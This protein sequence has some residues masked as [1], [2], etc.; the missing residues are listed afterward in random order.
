MIFKLGD[1]CVYCAVLVMLG[2]SAQAEPAKK[3]RSHKNLRYG[4]TKKSEKLHADRGKTTT[5]IQRPLPPSSKNNGPNTRV[6]LK[7][8]LLCSA[9][10]KKCPV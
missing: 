9:F 6:C 7:N 5:P 8:A 3:T 1:T 4:I 2:G 10:I